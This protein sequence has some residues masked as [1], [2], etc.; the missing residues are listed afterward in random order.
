MASWFELNSNA[1]K[2]IQNKNSKLSNWNVT[3]KLYFQQRFKFE[4]S[5]WNLEF[6]L[7]LEIEIAFEFAVKF[8]IRFHFEC[9]YKV[10]FGFEIWSHFSCSRSTSKLVC[11]A[12]CLDATT[13]LSNPSCPTTKDLNMFQSITKKMFHQ[14]SK[15]VFDRNK[16]KFDQATNFSTKTKQV[17]DENQKSFWLW[18]QS[19]WFWSKMLSVLGNKICDFDWKKF[20]VLAENFFWF[21]SILFLL[22]VEKKKFFR[23]RIWRSK[24]KLTSNNLLI[25]VG[26]K[27]FFG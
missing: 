8:L 12:G 5:Q 19:S 14:N 4:M 27:M 7:N 24:K 10:E 2:K 23:L 3:V 17:F 21:W 1:K 20:L 22:L 9:E 26:K 16:N 13:V 11:V 15:F 25:L 18:E 6:K